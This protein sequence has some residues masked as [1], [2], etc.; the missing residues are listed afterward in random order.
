MAALRT[1]A[2][3]TR[4]ALGGIR[5]INGALGLLA[6]AV[7]MK[8]LGDTAPDRNAAA[9]YGLRMFGVR[10]VVIGADL[11]RSDGDAL[12]RALS[13]APLIHASDTATVLTLLRR[14]QLAPELAR[15]LALISGVNT[16]LA[17]TAYLT[18]RRS[19]R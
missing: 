11:L 4:Y 9:I 1:V 17:V 7:I 10:T 2:T 16:A 12:S 14:K 8:R 5:I 3:V 6:P 15:P 19:G 13:A 18:H